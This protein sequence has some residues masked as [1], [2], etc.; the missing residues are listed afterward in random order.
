MQNYGKIQARDR[1]EEVYVGIALPFPALASLSVE[2]NVTSSV[3]ALNPNT[4]VLEVAA[5]GAAAA[6]RWTTQANLAASSSVIT[7]AG[8]N[9]FDLMIPAG[10]V[11]Q[12]VVPRNTQA[13]SSGYSSVVGLNV[14]EG[15]YNA[16]AIKSTQ[17]GSVL[18]TQY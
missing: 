17:I 11:R 4:T 13:L 14:L 8:T 2:N 6:I 7:A 18:L 10:T 1:G 9:G 15:L 12:I 16:V 5:T 3:T